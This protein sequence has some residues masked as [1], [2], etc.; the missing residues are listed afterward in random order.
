MF[1]ENA[2]LVSLNV[3]QWT[4]RKLDKKATKEVAINHGVNS[5]VGSYHK[6]I[7]PA[8]Y[9]L[10]AITKSTGAARTFYYANTLPW[11]MDGARVL[12]NRNYLEFTTEMR[13]LKS[14]WETH[15][16]EFVR[17][18]PHLK[19]QAQLTLNGLYNESDYPTDVRTKF[20]FDVSFMPVPQEGD[21]R[22]QLAQDEMAK[23]KD[24][25]VSAE[26][27]ANKDLWER[28]YDVAKKAADRLRDPDGVFRDSL[29]ENAVEL[30]DM[31]PRLNFTDDPQLEA[32]RREVESVLCG[33]A[34]EALRQLPNVRE[35]TVTGLDDILSK[36]SGYM[37][38]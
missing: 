11:A 19:S 5:S 38:A 29:V 22:I 27:E 37:T 36:M 17:Q 21:F 2:L 6:S 31:L 20:D 9:E 15:V 28:L 14:E 10:E 1:A 8:A 33:Q 30:C 34:P 16:N 25:I 26:R 7:L 24:S 23:F 3:S 35:K 12:P 32:M 18:Y 4:A 13:A